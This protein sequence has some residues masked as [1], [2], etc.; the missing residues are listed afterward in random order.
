MRK[1]ANTARARGLARRR[2]R[3]SAIW[4]PRHRRDLRRARCHTSGP[5]D[6]DRWDRRVRRRRCRARRQHGRIAARQTRSRTKPSIAMARGFPCRAIGAKKL[7]A[8]TSSPRVKIARPWRSA[9]RSAVAPSATACPGSRAHCGRGQR[10]PSRASAQNCRAV[11][12]GSGGDKLQRHHRYAVTG[13]RRAA[14]GVHI[15]G[16]DGV[17]KRNQ[18]IA[19]R[20]AH[21]RRA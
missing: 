11:L 8:R 15:A 14:G 2:P 1:C 19:R 17:A 3:G 18:P 5:G 7:A 13:L 20:V 10:A 16:A 6:A 12:G 21:Q 4:R 9:S